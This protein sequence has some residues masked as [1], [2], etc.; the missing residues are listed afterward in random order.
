MQTS[1]KTIQS[2]T[3]SKNTEPDGS[4]VRRKETLLADGTIVVDERLMSDFNHS[5]EWI[6][7]TIETAFAK[8][9]ILP[10]HLT[11]LRA[12]KDERSNWFRV[13][14]T[15]TGFILFLLILV[16][17]LLWY[18]MRTGQGVEDLRDMFDLRNNSN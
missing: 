15:I 14:C 9:S 17:I 18:L 5:L 6:P 1:G 10:L 3:I 11:S 7:T 13:L 2:I 12:S 8:N 16:Q 4:I